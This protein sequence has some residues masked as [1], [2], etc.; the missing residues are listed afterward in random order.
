MNIEKF[1][2]PVSMLAPTIDPGQLGFEDT[3]EL[4]PLTEII[5]QERAVEALEFGLNMKS[6]GFNLYVSGPVGTGKAT[7]IRQMVKRMAV[8]APAPS[9]WCYVNNFQDPSRPT[10]LALPAG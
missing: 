4:E 10:C 9:D 3:S 1:K 6:P 2:V 7:V 5:G 8:G